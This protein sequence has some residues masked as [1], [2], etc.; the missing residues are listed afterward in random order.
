MGM[1]IL[2][3]LAPAPPVAPGAGPCT[4]AEAERETA[5]RLGPF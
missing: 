5:S 3:G 1:I 4:L 2:P